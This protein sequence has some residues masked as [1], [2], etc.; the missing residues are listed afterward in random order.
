VLLVV[1]PAARGGAVELIEDVQR[2]CR[3]SG[4]EPVT[5]VP[6]GSA[7]AVS[8]V[9][10]A[11][12]EGGPWHCLVAIGGDGTVSTCAEAAATAIVPI[13]IVPAGTGNSLYRA[14]W[15]DRPWLEVLGEALSGTVSDGAI[16]DGATSEGAV[17]ERCIDLLRVAGGT[18]E[19]A[20]TALLGVS[21]GL[22][23]EVV[24]ASEVL[25]GVS[26]RER[27]SAAT[28]PALEAHVPF[29]ARIILDGEVLTEG[30]VSLVAVGGARHRAGTFELLPRSVLDDGLLDVCVIGG[31]DATGFIELAG[32]VTT[33]EHIGLP[34]VDYGQGHSVTIERTDGGWLPLEYDGDVWPTEERSITIEVMAQGVSMLAPLI[35]VAG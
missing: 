14:L 17:R 24:S 31:V 1:N 20:A 26:G 23:A 11:L 2:R 29:P 32:A 5:L 30:P 34:G 9:R 19:V 4:C 18:S 13:A 12:T 15:E 8:E 7:E 25:S 22:V 6:T 27:Y 21:A 35:P 3:D 28:G 33:G 10:S 16:S